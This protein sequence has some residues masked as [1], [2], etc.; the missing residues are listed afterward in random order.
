M[1]LAGITIRIASGVPCLAGIKI[2]N[3]PNIEFAISLHDYLFQ[4]QE[5]LKLQETTEAAKK[6]GE[7]YQETAS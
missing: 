1:A 5:A 3:V 7:A 6:E 4:A 2:N